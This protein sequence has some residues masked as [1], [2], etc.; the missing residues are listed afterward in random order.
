MVNYIETAGLCECSKGGRVVIKRKRPNHILHLLLSL[1]TGGAWIIIWILLC[2]WN[3]DPWKCTQCG[4]KN[5]K[6]A[7]N[8]KLPFMVGAAVF[9]GLTLGGGGIVGALFASASSSQPNWVLVSIAL[10]ISAAGFALYFKHRKAYL[11]VK[12]KEVR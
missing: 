2:V 9:V 12:K 7:P 6:L 1:V 10:I 4:S 5:V 8:P 11:E 3:Q